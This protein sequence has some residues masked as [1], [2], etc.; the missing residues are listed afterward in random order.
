M[1][2][3]EDDVR[4]AIE[5]VVAGQSIRKAALAWGILRNTL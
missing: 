2:Y 5:A 4:E 1:P 3:T